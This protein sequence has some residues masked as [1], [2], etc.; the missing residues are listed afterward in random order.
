MRSSTGGKLG[1]YKL[2]AGTVNLVTRQ[3]YGFVFLDALACCWC[4]QLTICLQVFQVQKKDTG[5]VYAMKVMRKERIIAKD[6]GEYVRAERNVLTAVFHPYI[7]T[8]RCSFQV[9]VICAWVTSPFHFCF[10]AY[11]PWDSSG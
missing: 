11:A 7:V 4:P 8:L 5:Q 9:C 6:H 3:P 2:R 1:V 10:V